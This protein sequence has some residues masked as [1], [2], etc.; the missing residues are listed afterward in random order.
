VLLAA[1][2]GCG[3]DDSRERARQAPAPDPAPPA[4]PAPDA[5]LPRAPAALAGA[6]EDTTTRLYTEIDDW[7]RDG[8]PARGAPPEAVTLLALH[9]QRI[10]LRLGLRPRLARRTLARLPTPL[11]REAR[12]IVRARRA[13]ASIRSV[14]RHRPQIRV[15]RAR[16][17]GEL[18]RYYRRAQRR[19]DVGWPLLA[20]VNFVESAFG[21]LRNTSVSGARGPMQFMPATWDA[22]GLGGNVRDPRDA[23]PGAANYLHASGAPGDEER[24]LYAYNPSRHYVDAI[25][26]YA[27]RIRRDRRAFYA[28]YAW[29]VFIR[30]GDGYRRLTGPSA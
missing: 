9:Q 16:P 12:D 23:I 8:D 30:S 18:L 19:F 14:V 15:G 28:F 27:R 7:R 26:R 21:R 10:Y 2:A 24:A 4:L 20:A 11:L 1:L 29:Q 13:L 17:A 5:P 6:L 22:Y 3:G 25:A